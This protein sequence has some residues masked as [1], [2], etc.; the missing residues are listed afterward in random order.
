MSPPKAYPLSEW[1]LLIAVLFPTPWGRSGR[2]LYQ[3][4]VG[5]AGELG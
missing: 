4:K 5:G 3:E 2:E 1:G